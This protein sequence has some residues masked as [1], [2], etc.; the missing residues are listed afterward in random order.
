MTKVRPPLIRET[1][2]ME[3]PKDGWERHENSV[4]LHRGTAR[5][6]NVHSRIR[7][8]MSKE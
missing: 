2:P 8:A 6:Q 4:N 7:K 3:V 1:T 5:E